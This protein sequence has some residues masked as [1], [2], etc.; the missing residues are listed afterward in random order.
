MKKISYLL[1]VIIAFSFINI[2]A[3][4][5]DLDFS[6]Q[7]QGCL[8]GISVSENGKRSQSFIAGISGSLTSVKAGISTG[9]CTEIN[10]INCVAN[11]R[12]A[13]C[14]G[15]ILATENFSIPTNT[16]LGMYEINFS[17]PATI[18]AG[19]VYT[20]ELSVLPNQICQMNMMMTL[21]ANVSWVVVSGSSCN[22]Y[23]GGTAYESCNPYPG[24]F[25]FQT[26]VLTST[27]GTDTRIECKSYEWID[28]NTYTSSNDTATFNIINGAVSGGDSIVTLN[29]TINN[30]SDL[31]TTTSGVSISANNIGAT[32]QW[33]DCDN[34]Y[35]IIPQATNQSFTPLVN[36]NYAVE[37]TENG[38]VD[39][40]DCVPFLAFGVIENSF[41]NEL[42]VYP[43]PTNGEFSIDLGAV[44]ENSTILITNVTGMLI[45]S[46]T[47]SQSQILNLSIS[48]QTGLYICTVQAADK[49]AVI[50]I[51]KK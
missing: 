7:N 34:N 21:K 20:L 2:N 14:D 18:V 38:C 32:Y 26:Y 46:K 41:D 13:T 35:A 51:L 49:K 4:T 37:I 36:G 1:L 40:S 8:G 45:D 17:T 22:E 15:Q 33:L 6:T 39:T 16:A 48:D 5:L 23:S 24:D 11:I 9:S 25:L 43:N 10:V 42:R 44:Y 30:V 50:R 31:S 27:T 12:S 29:L 3:Q 47:V 28:G 19:E